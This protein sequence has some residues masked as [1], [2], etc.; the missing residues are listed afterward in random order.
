MV[1]N[2]QISNMYVICVLRE[3]KTSKFQDAHY[4]YTYNFSCTLSVHYIKVHKVFELRFYGCFIALNVKQ[5]ILQEQTGSIY[6]T[7]L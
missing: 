4:R 1:T 7:V 2:P 5:I 6:S 3:M